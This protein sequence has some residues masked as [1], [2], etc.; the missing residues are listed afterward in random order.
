MVIFS[1]AMSVK[2]PE[3]KPPFSYGFSM[4]LWFSYGFP[5]VFLWFS[6]GFPTMQKQWITLGHQWIT[7]RRMPLD[8]IPSRVASSG[9]RFVVSETGGVKPQ[10][11]QREVRSVMGVCILVCGWFKIDD[12]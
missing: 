10:R 11:K 1:I 8:S 3:G 2:L 6:Y 12:N 5:M 7:S 4:V 9:G